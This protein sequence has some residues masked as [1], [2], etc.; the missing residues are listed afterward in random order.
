MRASQWAG[1]FTALGQSRGPRPI[2]GDV[3]AVVLPPE[4]P[5]DDEACVVGVEELPLL[6]LPLHDVSGSARM[7]TKKITINSDLECCNTTPFLFN[8]RAEQRNRSKKYNEHNSEVENQFLYTA[9]RFKNCSSA[10]ATEN[11]P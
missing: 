7:K 1:A 9:S 3:V 6:L 4:F 5:P 11:A 10:A 8:Q 2:P